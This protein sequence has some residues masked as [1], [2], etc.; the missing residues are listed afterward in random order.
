MLAAAFHAA[1]SMCLFSG[2]DKTTLAQQRMRNLQLLTALCGAKI[3]SDLAGELTRRVSYG[4]IAPLL[5]DTDIGPL[6]ELG[7]DIII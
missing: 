1:H 4:L 7:A 2:T 3:Q 6:K 5:V